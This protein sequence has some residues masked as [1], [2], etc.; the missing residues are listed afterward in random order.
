MKTTPTNTDNGKK[1]ELVKKW[2]DFLI[3]YHESE[4]AKHQYKLAKA[5]KKYLERLKNDQEN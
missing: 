1:I 3:A 5:R 2:R 4:I